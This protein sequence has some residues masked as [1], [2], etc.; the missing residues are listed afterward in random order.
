[1]KAPLEDRFHS[2]IMA[3]T[4]GKGCWLWTGSSNPDG[5]GNLWSGGKMINAHRVS[6]SLY[7]GAIPDGLHVLHKCDVPQCVNPDHLFLGSH[8][9][10]MADRAAKG[11]NGCGAAK[12]SAA[13]VL[14]IL[15]LKGQ[16]LQREIGAM[17]GVSKQSVSYI[18]ARQ[19]WKHLPTEER[20][21]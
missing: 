7:R 10:N 15:A 3:D 12:L 6:W 11:R 16:M 8:A 9:D 17:F 5:Y 21:A 4:N 13:D 2:R 19:T 1:M 18:H 14:K 20:I